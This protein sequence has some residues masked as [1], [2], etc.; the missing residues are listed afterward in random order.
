MLDLRVAGKTIFA[1][2]PQSSLQRFDPGTASPHDLPDSTNLVKFGLQLVN[3]KKDG[4]KASDLC[5]CR[6]SRHATHVSLSLDSYLCLSVQLRDV[7]TM[8]N[9]PISRADRPAVAAAE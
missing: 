6:R 2:L 7:N 5:V 8:C 1:K 9:P 3:L 4:S